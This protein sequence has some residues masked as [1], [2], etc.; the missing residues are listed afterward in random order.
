MIFVLGGNTSGV[1]LSSQLE[2]GVPG[3]DFIVLTKE[4]GSKAFY[5][6]LTSEQRRCVYMELERFVRIQKKIGEPFTHDEK[7]AIKTELVGKYLKQQREDP[8]SKPGEILTNEEKKALKKLCKAE[9]KKHKKKKK[10]HEKRRREGSDGDKHNPM[11]TRDPRELPAQY[12]DLPYQYA[13]PTEEEILEANLSDSSLGRSKRHRSRERSRDRDNRDNRRHHR[14]RDREDSHRDRYDSSWDARSYA[15]GSTGSRNRD[16]DRR[17][18]PD[19]RG[20]SHG[21]VRYR[22]DYHGHDRGGSQ[23]NRHQQKW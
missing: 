8:N 9:R 7:A 16:Q 22:G 15:S 18:S 13:E 10:K 3:V 20:H 5:A 2:R 1:S 12:V 21:H 14:D 19:Q 23:G 4:E 11:P 6:E 17:R